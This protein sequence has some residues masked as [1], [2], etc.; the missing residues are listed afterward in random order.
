[1]S[2]K[3]GDMSLGSR[4]QALREQRVLRP[5]KVKREQ[6]WAT[7]TP[8]TRKTLN[9]SVTGSSEQLILLGFVFIPNQKPDLQ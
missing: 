9:P 4:D 3:L 1:M 6:C 2:W 7:W 5:A 8:H